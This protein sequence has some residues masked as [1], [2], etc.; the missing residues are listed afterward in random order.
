MQIQ[1]IYIYQISEAAGPACPKF[2]WRTPAS[3]RRRSAIPT[4]CFKPR[5]SGSESLRSIY[6]V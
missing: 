2:S 6:H 3:P 1:L 5:R 4:P